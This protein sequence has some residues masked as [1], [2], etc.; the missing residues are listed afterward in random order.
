MQNYIVVFTFSNL[1]RDFLGKFGLKNQNFRFKL[2]FG[3][4][5]NLNMQNSMVKIV[6]LSLKLG[7]ENNSDMQ[8]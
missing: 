5:T 1:N 7:T 2:K 6:S 3:T 4:K 8:N